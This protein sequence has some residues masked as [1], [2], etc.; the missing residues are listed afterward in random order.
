MDEIELGTDSYEYD[1][2]DFEG[3]YEAF[4]QSL[5]EGVHA[6][7]TDGHRCKVGH[8]IPHK[9]DSEE[10][11]RAVYRAMNNNFGPFFPDDHGLLGDDISI[12]TISYIAK[13]L[14]SATFLLVSR[15]YSEEEACFE[16]VALLLK[17]EWSTVKNP[18]TLTQLGTVFEE[19]S[20]GFRCKRV[21]T[22]DQWVPSTLR[23]ATDGRSPYENVKAD[24]D[25]GFDELDEPALR[26]WFRYTRLKNSFEKSHPDVNLSLLVKRSLMPLLPEAERGKVFT[27]FEAECNKI[28]E[29]R[30]ALH[31]RY[32]AAL[33]GTAGTESGTTPETSHECD[34]LDRLMAEAMFKFL[35]NDWL[36]NETRQTY[37]NRLRSHIERMERL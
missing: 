15:F 27:K 17:G 7:L 35:A 33:R 34:L 8:P 37:L 11:I 2:D 1:R 28:F 24:G 16:T 13:L 25:R 4:M 10:D 14:A 23:R 21:G 26:Y 6:S 12:R 18:G 3:N 9:L 36:A 32:E 5:P 29:Q 22:A 31:E 30:A 19:V 20:T